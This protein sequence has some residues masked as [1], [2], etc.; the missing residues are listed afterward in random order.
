MFRGSVSVT[1]LEINTRHVSHVWVS[2][3]ADGSFCPSPL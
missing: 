2:A 3:R 1:E